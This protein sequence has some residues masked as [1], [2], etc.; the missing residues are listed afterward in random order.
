MSP[1]SA[2]GFFYSDINWGNNRYWVLLED[3]KFDQP[4][5]ENHQKIGAAGE[6]SW[7]AG[8]TRGG[9]WQLLYSEKRITPGQYRVSVLAKN[10]H[11]ESAATPL[12]DNAGRYTI[13]SLTP[14]HQES[15]KVKLLIDPDN[16]LVA[17]ISWLCDLS[18]PEGGYNV[19]VTKPDRK[20]A[21][22]FPR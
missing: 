16:H 4:T 14:P 20:S 19:T 12:T 15:I 22:G 6:F 10:N 18:S 3:S 2:G 5:R 11:S 17:N 21:D 1:F 7:S 13:G 8:L 9:W